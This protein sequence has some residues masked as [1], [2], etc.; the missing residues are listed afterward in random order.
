VNTH[1][2]T[3]TVWIMH[4]G[5]LGDWVLL[6]PLLRALARSGAHIIAVTHSSK[7][8]LA[9]RW[10]DAAP[11]RISPLPGGI[12]QP[13][14]SRWWAG[15][16]AP[17]DDAPAHDWRIPS[18]DR[19]LSFLCDDATPAGRAWLAAAAQAF[20]RAAIHT[21]GPP[22]SRSRQELW[23][24]ERIHDLARIAP[25]IN[26]R[27]PILCHIG[28]GSP[29][30]RWPL[31]RWAGLIPTLRTPDTDVIAIAGEAERDRL[32][33]ADLAAFSTLNGCF[34]DS[35]DDLAALTAAARLFIGTD[36]GPTHLAAQL[37]IP[38]LA[39][40]GP[41]DPATWSPIGP[42]IRILA[43]DSPRPMDWLS[44]ATLATI[45]VT[46]VDGTRFVWNDCTRACT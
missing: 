4:A 6:W 12:D 17:P 35:L 30:K 23:Q 39:L 24:R 34:I 20:P 18:P 15:P 16:I 38:T 43:P 28:A 3:P 13:P 1:E 27:G 46:G 5:A 33:P 7:A 26:P 14:L 8:D 9:A 19:I 42:A 11:G 22:A 36:T 45:A 29:D 44:V 25:R 37:G 41:T 31:D 32:T 21:V 10:I 2:S 40:F